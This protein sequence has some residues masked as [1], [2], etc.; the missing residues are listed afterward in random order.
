VKSDV[1]SD[2]YPLLPCSEDQQGDTEV[3]EL[4]LKKEIKVNIFPFISFYLQDHILF[5]LS[6]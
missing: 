5:T 3:D 1:C 2:N 6:Y 4:A